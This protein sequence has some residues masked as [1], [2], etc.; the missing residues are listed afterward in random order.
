MSQTPFF[1]VIVPTYNRAHLIS[2][3]ISSILSQTYP[4]FELI[5]VDD[6]S[7]DNTE[8]VVRQFVSDRVFYYKKDNAERAA[9]RNYGTHKAKGDYVNW[10]DSDDMMLP[11]NLKQAAELIVKNSNPEMIAMCHQHVDTEGRTL[12]TES[13]PEEI[14]GNL[15]K[16]NPMANSPV[17]VRRDIAL[18]NQFNEDRGLS[19]SED[20]ELWLRLAAQYKI[21][22]TSVPTVS[23]VFHDQRSVLTMKDPNQL[24]TRYSKFIQYSTSDTKV[25]S[26]LNGN[27]GFFEMKNY[28]LLA[29]DL[30][31]HDFRNLGARYIL[32]AFKSSTSLLFQRGFYAFVK[33]YIF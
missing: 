20:Y 31:G 6:G 27:K 14:N 2:P 8:E 9:A 26:L 18:T 5:I 19:G 25:L 17:M 33:H 24:I 32:K 4:H 13:Y 10:F 1:S 16:S 12:H 30:V 3:T 23:I 7:T 29:V 22:S 15:Y 21:Y 11:D 28:L